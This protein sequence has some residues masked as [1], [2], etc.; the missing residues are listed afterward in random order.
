[1]EVPANIWALAGKVAE[2]WRITHIQ[3]M[4]IVLDHLSQ[5]IEKTNGA[6]LG[7]VFQVAYEGLIAADSAPID[8]LPS[9]DVSKIHRS[10]KTKSGF[11][12]VYANGK[13]FRA[14]AKQPGEGR[15][16]KSIGTFPTA[17]RAG[18]ARYIFYKKHQLPY[19]ELEAMLD[20]QD[21]VAQYYRDELRRALEREP[22]DL[23]VLSEINQQRRETGKPEIPCDVELPP[24]V[25][26][27]ETLK[28]VDMAK[29]REEALRYGS[30]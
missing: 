29:A 8:G 10:A 12:G 16:Q 14:M 9:I 17:E 6:V 7:D 15:I 27:T 3:G 22:T 2:R 30:K 13:G 4:R 19:G 28:N 5:R 11:V 25:F 1:M 24:P 26:V 23:E 20:E 18:W 21:G